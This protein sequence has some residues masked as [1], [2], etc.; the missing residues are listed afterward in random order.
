MST[1]L[2]D[3]SSEDSLPW[4]QES[5]LAAAAAQLGRPLAG[6]SRVASRCHLEL[7]VVLECH[8][9]REGQPFPTLYYLSCPLARI[10]VSR[11]EAAG[12]VRDW[13]ARVDAEP[14]LAT[15]LAAAHEAYAQ[16]RSR[17]LDESDPEQAKL[18]E[19]LSGGIG[20]SRGVKCLHAH[21]AHARVGGTNP[22]GGPVQAEVEPLNCTGPCVAQGAKV[23]AWRAP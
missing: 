22:I 9:D 16:R 8:P 2:S 13:T 5:D 1:P 7:P 17:L 12:G 11:I 6:R 21:Y 3:A 18:A 4:N 23:A 19:K 20:G 10:R 14:E 15:A